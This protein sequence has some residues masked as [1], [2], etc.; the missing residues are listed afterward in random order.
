MNPDFTIFKSIDIKS[1]PAKVWEVLT[2]PDLIKEYFTGA[3]TITDWQI[4]SE[5]IFIHTYEDQEFRN[6]G[7]II[8]FS[9][10]HILRY[11]Y[12]TAFSKT[13]D[14]PENYTTITY[15]LTKIN[16]KTNLTLRQTNLK[17]LEWYKGLEI[18]WN[19]VLD[20]IKEIAER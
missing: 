6:K 4:G 3:E 2:N 14:K 11:S 7:I 15:A 5:I 13:D 10:N 20:K 19:T 18:G 9:P 1:S 16:D 17:D 8:D 12:W